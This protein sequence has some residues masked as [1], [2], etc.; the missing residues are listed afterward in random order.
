[1]TNKLL[2]YGAY[3]QFVNRQTSLEA[4]YLGTGVACQPGKLVYPISVL[5]PRVVGK[6]ANPCGSSFPMKNWSAGFQIYSVDSVGRIACPILQASISVSFDTTPA[7]A[8]G[9]IAPV[10]VKDTL[11]AYLNESDDDGY[12]TGVFGGGAVAYNTADIT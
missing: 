3:T 9:N 10:D 5:R 4:S 8:G 1:M 6:D 12:F 11:L 7:N 2:A